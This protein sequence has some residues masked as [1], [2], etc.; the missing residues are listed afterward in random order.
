MP[1]PN[2]ENP[3]KQIGQ[4]SARIEIESSRKRLRR[5]LGM[6]MLQWRGCFIRRVCYQKGKRDVRHQG[7]GVRL[8]LARVLYGAYR[9]H[10]NPTNKGGRR[11]LGRNWSTAWAVVLP[12]QRCLRLIAQ[13]SY[14]R[15]PE[16]FS[17]RREGHKL[18]DHLFLIVAVTVS[19]IQCPPLWKLPISQSGPLP[20]DLTSSLSLPRH[21]LHRLVPVAQFQ[22]ADHK[23]PK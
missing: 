19:T 8:P 7:Q 10:L 20:R 21:H 6:L 18:A 2:Q 11:G 12:R 22:K 16:R 9:H 3:K 14:F 15:E 4:S 5:N 17:W 1:A 13:I 23:C